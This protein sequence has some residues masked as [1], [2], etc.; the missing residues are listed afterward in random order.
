[1]KKRV[2]TKNWSRVLTRSES[3][4]SKDLVVARMSM[5][6]CRSS[7]AFAFMLAALCLGSGAAD[8]QVTGQ[9]QG[10]AAA[11]DPVQ[12]WTAGWQT[13]FG[14]GA[15]AG[16]DSNPYG[17]LLAFGGGGSAGGNFS[18]RYNFENGWFIGSA[19]GGGFGMN[20]FSPTGA[21]G[22]LGSLSHEGTQFGYNFS[23]AP[24]SV[25]AGFDTLRYNSGIGSPLSGFDSMS[26]PTSPGYG[27]HA[28]VE[29][30]PTSNLS[31]SLGVGYA[32]QPTGI[33]TG[34]N[35]FAVPGATSFAFGARR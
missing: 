19:R 5:I 2:E 10:Q 25:Y 21:W 8:A 35:S 12:Y 20:G 34:N 26:S 4:G 15:S 11:V 23:N 24:V 32:Q 17:S 7:F 9:S 6:S 18:S 27:V 28:G 31:L 13:G 14:G 22:N 29:I 33:D 30:R 3:N 1:V 16:L